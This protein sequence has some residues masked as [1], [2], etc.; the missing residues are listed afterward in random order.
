MEVAA[1]LDDIDSPEA[2]P[3]SAKTGLQDREI[4]DGAAEAYLAVDGM[5]CTTCEA[6]LD[7]RGDEIDSIHSVDA[8]YAMETVR[9]VYDP[10]VIAE[11][12]LPEPLSGMVMDVVDPALGERIDTY[13]EH[14]AS[15][16]DATL[17]NATEAFRESQM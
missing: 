10:D 9:V 5:H 6:F 8:N 16:I 1:K 7:I 12:D 11:A 17:E 4:P 14:T 2:N 15:D 13:E 3:T